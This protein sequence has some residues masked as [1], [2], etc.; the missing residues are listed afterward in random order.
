MLNLVGI[1]SGVKLS[2][3]SYSPTSVN[4]TIDDLPF[5]FVHIILAFN[6]PL[7]TRTIFFSFPSSIAFIKSLNVA[8]ISMLLC[9]VCCGRRIRTSDLQ[10]VSLTS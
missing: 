5:L 4:V 2:T 6:P 10:V 8:C 9:F 3:R 1:D 7:L